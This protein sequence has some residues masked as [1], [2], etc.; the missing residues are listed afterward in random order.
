MKP[1]YDGYV[2]EQVRTNGHS[3][4]EL[5]QELAQDSQRLVTLEF[6]L[7]KSELAQK[8]SQA[9]KDVA[10]LVAGGLVAYAGFLAIVLAVVLGL[11]NLMPVW[12]AALIVGV[13]VALAGYALVQKGM[14]SLRSLNPAPQQTV[15]SLRADKEM[16]QEQLR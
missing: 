14:S 11:A 13:V 8:A 9:G 1:G 15:D 7:A 12:L 16:V 2:T 3:I 6:A 5:F 10:I 4:G